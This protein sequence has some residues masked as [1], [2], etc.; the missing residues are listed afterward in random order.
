MNNKK[1]MPLS[2]IKVLEL[3]TVVAAPTTARMLCAYGAEVI[4][5]EAAFGDSQ[6]EVGT[7]KRVPCADYKNPLF[8]VHNSNKTLISVNI[9]SE[10]GREII[11]R[12]LENADVFITNVRVAS[13]ARSGL[14][15]DSLKERFPEL[16]YAQFYGFGPMGPAAGDPGYDSTAFWMRSG[17]PSD[18]T[19]DGKPFYPTYAFGDMA[20]SSVLLSG[21]LMALLSRQST[22]KGTMVSTSLYASGIWCNATG[23]VQTQFELQDLNPD[24]NDPVGPFDAF[25]PCADNTWI[26][27]YTT[28]YKKNCEVFARVFEL[29][30]IVEDSRW[31]SYTELRKSGYMPQAVKKVQAAL[32][33]KTAGEWREILS[34]NN[35]ACEE[36]KKTREV[37]KDEQALANG[38]VEALT[39]A[40][41]TEI[42]MPSPPIHFSDMDRKPYS[43]CGRIGENTCEVMRELGF[44]ENAISEMA[45]NGDIRI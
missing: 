43:V 24:Y 35:I 1:N 12:L 30:E 26:A 42:K 14:D 29:P 2:G 16:V 45:Q 4:K 32:S 18:W 39:Y 23:V 37:S 31:S 15:Y 25:H 21:I 20:T 28:N 10:K 36:M 11:F 19:E 41:G 17:P 9:K 38:Y 3:S 8:D 40:D 44:S 13:L 6:R 33:K 22:G 7:G 5:I 27:I 34:A